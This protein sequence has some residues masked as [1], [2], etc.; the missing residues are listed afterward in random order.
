MLMQDSLPSRRAEVRSSAELGSRPF[1]DIFRGMSHD[2]TDE[3]LEHAFVQVDGHLLELHGRW[4]LFRNLY[5]G[6]ADSQPILAAVASETFWIFGRLLHR[7]SFLLYRQ[8]TD[9][10]R[11]MGK[12][13]ASLEGLLEA[14]A[15]DSYMQDAPALMKF[16]DAARDRPAIRDHVNKYVAHLDFDLMAGVGALPSIELLAFEEALANMRAFMN[17]LGLKYFDRPARAHDVEAKLLTEQADALVKALR[18]GSQA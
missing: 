1:G 18:K 6:N 14:V 10:P 9:A 13:N 12:R 7:G 11:S 16:L 4:E 3:Q 5:R 17:G 2:Y 8:L 15:G